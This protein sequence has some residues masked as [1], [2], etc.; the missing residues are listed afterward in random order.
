MPSGAPD[1]DEH[2]GLSHRRLAYAVGATVTV[3]VVVIGLLETGL[4]TVPRNTTD[5]ARALFEQYGLAALCGL[6]VIEGAMLLYFAPSESLV[7]AAVL[8]LADSTGDVAA[9]V[10]VAVVGATVG[11]T[12]LF[13]VAKRGGRE[14]V[15]ERRWI[16]IDEERLDRFE[17]WFDRWGPVVIPVSN[18]LL[19]T[20]GMLTIPAGLAEMDTHTF[21]SLSALGTLSF[22][23]L[24]ALV[25]IYGADVVA[26]LGL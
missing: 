13:V 15:H 8:F 18:T 11:Q 4:V 6:F 19:F 1:S 25:T 14:L 12:L 23:G 20:R 26:T 21:V 5:A 22:E 16:S 17:S 3:A 2:A 24:L 9:I 10:A 7:P